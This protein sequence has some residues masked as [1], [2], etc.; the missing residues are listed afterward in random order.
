MVIFGSITTF[1]FAALQAGAYD[2]AMFI[3]TRILN[4]A[5]VGILTSCVSH[6]AFNT[7]RLADLVTERCHRTSLSCE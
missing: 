4:G 3:V 7:V 6:G 2:L 1:V 5:A